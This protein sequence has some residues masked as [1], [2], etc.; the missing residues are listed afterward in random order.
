MKIAILS[1]HLDDAAF[2]CGLLMTELLSAGNEILTVNVCTSSRY[3][4][5]LTEG[6]DSGV[7]S[8]SEIRRSEDVDFV[9]KLLKHSSADPKA[10]STIDLGWED[11]PI[12]WQ[13]EDEK[14]LSP[15]DL[16]AAEV[17]AL[18]VAFRALPV[19]DLALS[20]QALGGH[21]DHRLV[22][23]SANLAFPSEN[24]VL[25]EDLP[26]ACSEVDRGFSRSTSG[27]TWCA[28]WLP[29]NQA[30][31]LKLEYALCY[32]SQIAPELA[33]DMEKYAARHGGSEHYLANP[34]A[35][36]KLKK[37]LRKSENAL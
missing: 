37:G 19:V 34:G 21:I 32:P 36:D 3:A 1:P 8:V 4:P 26:Y 7:R 15:R 9:Q 25:Y 33:R 13:M 18:R 27:R 10:V 14:A 12:R 31:R 6:T 29:M 2:S 17:E 28:A 35:M 23:E 16:R 11:V 24:I 22:L 5:Y 20:P 30:N